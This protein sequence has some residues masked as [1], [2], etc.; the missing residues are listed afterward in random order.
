MGR[1]PDF[2]NADHVAS[3]LSNS[4]KADISDT[5]HFKPISAFEWGKVI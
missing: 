5:C 3:A 1:K 4:A 2:I